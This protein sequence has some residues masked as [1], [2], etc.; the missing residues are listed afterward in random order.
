[1]KIQPRK[2]AAV[3]KYAALMAAA[4]MLTGCGYDGEVALDGE[5]QV[6][7]SQ[8]QIDGD[9][10]V[11][12]DPEPSDP[13]EDPA[14]YKDGVPAAAIAACNS[15]EQLESA[16][17]QYGISLFQADAPADVAG[18][19]QATGFLD[20]D[21]TVHVCFFTA[22]CGK[23]ELY[24]ENGFAQ[25]DWGFVGTVQYPRGAAEQIAIRTAFIAAEPEHTEGLTAEEAAQI[26]ADLMGAADDT[27]E[28]PEEVH[29]DEN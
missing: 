2:T 9:M 23:E 18:E 16:F 11:C 21:D 10:Q 6:L 3:P 22:G 14:D 1:M 19:Y 8:V 29:S 27:S 17:E 7:D 24:A 28:E 20:N 5:T 12:P 13:E 26:A 25:H 15:Q 4:V